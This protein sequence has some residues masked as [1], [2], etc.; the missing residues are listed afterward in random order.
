MNRQFFSMSG[1]MATMRST[2]HGMEQNIAH[3]PVITDA[4]MGIRGS[5][6]SMRTDVTAMNG[7]I[8]SLNREVHGITSQV[9]GMNREFRSID[10]AIQY[11]G[12]DVYRMSGP[13]RMFNDL[14]PFD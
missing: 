8:A 2:L 7:T 6:S 3:V 9:H 1:D 5:V 10:P 12:R 13:M 14:N 4:T 11:M